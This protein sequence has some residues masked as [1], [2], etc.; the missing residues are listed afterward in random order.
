M[1]KKKIPH[2][3]NSS[4]IKYQKIKKDIIDTSNTHDRSLS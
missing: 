3:R 2:S 1:K 4:K